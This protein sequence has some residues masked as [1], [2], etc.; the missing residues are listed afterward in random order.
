MTYYSVGCWA[1]STSYFEFLLGS[2]WLSFKSLQASLL[3]AFTGFLLKDLN[4]VTIR[5]GSICTTIM[6]LGPA[7]PSRDGLW[8]QNSIMVV[9]MD[10]LTR[11]PY[12][13]L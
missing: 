6:E 5:R 9:Y 12:Y 1:A 11:K 3:A 4:E 2:C 10:P 13:L 8:V 7:R